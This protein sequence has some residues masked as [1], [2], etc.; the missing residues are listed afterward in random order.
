MKT[1]TGKEQLYMKCLGHRALN[2]RNM[3]K[4]KNSCVCVDL[5]AI[6]E[7]YNCEKL[8]YLDLQCIGQTGS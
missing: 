2:M 5:E 7:G 6:Y 3:T 4:V 8:L 1:M